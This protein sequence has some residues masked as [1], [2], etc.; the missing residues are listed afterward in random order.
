ASH[1]LLA[2]PAVAM[3]SRVSNA[4]ERGWTAPVGRLPA[5]SACQPAGA[6]WL[7]VASAN[8][9]RQELPVQRNRTFIADATP[10]A[11]SSPAPRVRIDDLTNMEIIETRRVRVECEPVPRR[12]I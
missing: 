6:R 9:D 7:N 5:L 2:R 11:T 1:D 8:M 12:Q 4:S 3:P 10:A